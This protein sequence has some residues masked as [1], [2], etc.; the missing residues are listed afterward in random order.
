MASST[1]DRT[2][3][4]RAGPRRQN[5]SV[6]ARSL[7]GQARSQRERERRP[8]AAAPGA[9]LGTRNAS[10]SN[11]RYAVIIIDRACPGQVAPVP[12]IV[13]A[14]FRCAAKLLFGNAGNVAA[15]TGVVFE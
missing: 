8:R 15:E 10:S 9:V 6:R 1:V 3:T 11:H 12:L 7:Q 14:V 4:R 13:V 2:D 5:S